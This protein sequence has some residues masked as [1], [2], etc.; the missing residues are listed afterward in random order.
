M[1][2]KSEST[3]NPKH[4]RSYVLV[5]AAHNE[6][7]FIRKTLAAVTTQ[8]TLP[9]RWVIVS[10][11]STDGTDEIVKDYAR[12]FEFLQLL[13][14]GERHEHNFGSKVRALNAGLA[15]LKED[16]YEFIGILDADVSF[17]PFY[18][19]TLLERFERDPVL[20]LAGGSVH[21]AR[22]GNF[23]PRP[24]NSSRSV[25]GAIQLFRRECQETFGDF[26][27]LKYGGEDWFA[28]I[29]A[30]I[31]GWGVETFPELTVLHLK[32]TGIAAASRLRY[33]YRQ[34]LMDYALGSDPF[35]EVFKCLRRFG[36]RPY[37]L[38]A[39]S[40]F[41]GFVLAS[42]RREK[43]PVTREFIEYLRSEQ[44]SRMR[45]LFV[46]PLR[47]AMGRP[48]PGQGLVISTEPE[49]P[50]LKAFNHS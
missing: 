16:D 13:R 27:A 19:A 4:N 12:R 37:I 31:N 30:K 18:F 17:E 7:A 29:M 24:D 41:S 25:A 28:E 10:D 36:G 11:A 33:Y 9:K 34:G 1:P 32:P 20:G 22:D 26:L 50:T 5:T 8:T 43:R 49:R 3:E 21:E 47:R 6:E 23:A 38:G 35:F 39:L 44:K 45:D 15:E 48:K 46:E 2:F 14:I 40:R 42:C